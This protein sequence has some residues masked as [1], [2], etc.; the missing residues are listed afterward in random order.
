MNKTLYRKVHRFL[1]LTRDRDRMDE[2]RQELM[3]RLLE[4]PGQEMYV[5]P[6]HLFLSQDGEVNIEVLRAEEYDQLDLPF[7]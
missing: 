1:R 2:L 5:G 4:C 3:R 6:F 7:H